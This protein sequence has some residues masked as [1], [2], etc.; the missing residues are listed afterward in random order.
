MAW[1]VGLQADSLSLRDGK[2][3][4]MVCINLNQPPL[5]AAV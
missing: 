5:T 1:W 2:T 4:D 3:P